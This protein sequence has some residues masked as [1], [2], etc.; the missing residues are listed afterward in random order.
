MTP[1]ELGSTW[2]IALRK[3]AS[4]FVVSFEAASTDE[5][6]RLTCGASYKGATDFV[7]KYLWPWPARQVTRWCAQTGITPNA[8]TL[9]SLVLV[10]VTMWLFAEGHF[11]IGCTVGFLMTFLDTVDGKLARVTL[12]SSKWGER[13]EEHTSELQSLMRISYAV[14]CLK[15]KQKPKKLQITYT[16]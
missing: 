1:D 16:N 3:K 10:F 11:L 6:E 2:N 8:V 9:F 5:L 7:T 13:S 4:P 15:K 12:T 14:F